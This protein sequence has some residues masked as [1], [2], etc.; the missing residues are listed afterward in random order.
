MRFGGEIGEMGGNWDTMGS[1]WGH[2]IRFGS[3]KWNSGK[4]TVRFL[5][6]KREK[7]G[8]S[9]GEMREIGRIWEKMGGKWRK[10]GEMGENGENWDTMG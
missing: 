8:K 1:P 2:P 7:L 4:Y 10:W 3:K 6:W 9:W 5:G